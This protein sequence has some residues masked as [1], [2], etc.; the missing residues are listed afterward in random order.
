MA[1]PGLRLRRETPGQDVRVHGVDIVDVENDPYL[2]C[3]K[4]PIIDAH[5]IQGSVPTRN[6]VK[7]SV[8]PP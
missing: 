3:R 8:S 6:D 7:A 1:R 4:R 2:T 5:K